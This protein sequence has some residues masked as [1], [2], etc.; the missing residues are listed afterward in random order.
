MEGLY[1]LLPAPAIVTQESDPAAYKVLTSFWAA[2]LNLSPK[3]IVSPP[4]VKTLAKTI[5]YL[6]SHTE[7]DFAFRGRGYSSLPTKDVLVSLHN[8]DEFT[9]D[10]DKQTITVGAGQSW[11]TVYEALERLAPNY[12]VVGART[13]SVSVGG[14]VVTAGFSW[15]SGKFGCIS[16]PQNMIDCEV[17]KYDGSVVWA[18]TEPALLWAIRGGG[19]G[20]GAIT[21]IIFQLHPISRSIYYGTVI[22]PMSALTEVTH[23]ISEFSTSTTVDPGVS[24]F[25]FIQR[26]KFRAMH[27]S[28][29]SKG[30]GDV[31]VFQLFDLNGETHGRQAFSWALELPGAKDFTR[32]GSMLDVIKIQD[33]VSDLIGTSRQNW[34]TIIVPEFSVSQIQHSAQWFKDL[35]T[36]GNS[37][38]QNTYM[39]YELFCTKDSPTPAQLSWPGPRGCK[40]MLVIGLGCDLNA[41]DE[42]IQR[43]QELAQS[44]PSYLM[45]DDPRITPTP[46]AIEEWSDL[47]KIYGD[48]YK[49][50]LKLRLKYDPKRRFKGSIKITQS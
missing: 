12:T 1:S 31:L 8:L 24:A 26:E 14:T 35:G 9:Y 44:A 43:A 22:A 48:N 17:V 25:M 37:I 3:A 21:K 30:D 16:D 50:L 39:I 27:E 5:Q 36:H 20:Y 45:G 18:S 33:R 40:H 34:A 19:G 49:D 6:Y 2:Q 11:M 32:E 28:N 13:P 4:D 42:V 23:R 15:L 46:N 10:P 38:A 29:E 47:S 41:A 7:L